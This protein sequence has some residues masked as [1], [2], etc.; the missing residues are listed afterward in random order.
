MQIVQGDNIIAVGTIGKVEY[1]TVGANNAPL[2]KVSIATMKKD[3]N[4]TWVN[5]NFWYDKAKN[6]K[7]FSAGDTLHVEGI[8]ST[9]QAASGKTYS[10]VNVEY[11]SIIEKGERKREESK[12]APAQL[13]T[14]DDDDLPF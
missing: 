11:Y 8:L 14:I 12:P 10:N 13:T 7:E 3:D 2:T 4:T 6:A 5:C 9:Y 1:K